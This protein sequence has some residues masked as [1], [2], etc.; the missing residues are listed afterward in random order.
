MDTILQNLQK[1]DDSDVIY[2]DFAKAFDKIL[3]KN[4]SSYGTKGKFYDW[5]R[6]FLTNRF[7]TVCV[8]GHKFFIALVI[9][10]VP[11]S[12]V[13]GRILFIIFRVSREN[14]LKRDFIFLTDFLNRF[15][16]QIA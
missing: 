11:Q 12:S 15:F 7:Q 1:G 2:L 8:D 16:Y 14:R 10:G 6:D 4:L 13:L 5:I 9:N 3:L